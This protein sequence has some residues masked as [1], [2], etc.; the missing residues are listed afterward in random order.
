MLPANKVIPTQWAQQDDGSYRIDCTGCPALCCKFTDLLIQ[1]DMPT[2][3]AGHCGYLDAD[4]RCTIYETRPDI[5]RAGALYPY[6]RQAQQSAS[7]KD[8]MD[9]SVRTCDALKE[10]YWKTEPVDDS[11]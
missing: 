4:E 6:M 3:A 8:Y 2:T 7:M 11:S 1:L 10:G 9:R 5:C